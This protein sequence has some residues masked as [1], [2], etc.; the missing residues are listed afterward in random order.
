MTVIEMCGAMQKLVSE[1]KRC[2]FLSEFDFQHELAIVLEAYG[3]KVRCEVRTMDDEWLD[4]VV[5]DNKG[6][7][8]AVIE[9]KYKTRKIAEGLIPNEVR[10][11]RNKKGELGDWNF[12]Q[13]GARADNKSRYEADLKKLGKVKWTHNRYAIFLTNDYLYWDQY[14]GKGEDAWKNF[15]HLGSGRADEKSGLIFKYYIKQ[16]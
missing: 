15:S 7:V 6:G 10:N 12:I 2:F 8:E 3:A 5:E 1:R 4:I 13:Q 16:C 9:L 11:E 14:L